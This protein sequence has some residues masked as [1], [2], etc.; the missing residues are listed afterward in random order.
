MTG[1]TEAITR[2]ADARDILQLKALWKTVFGDDDADIAHFFETYFSP[3]QTVVI[4]GDS[5]QNGEAK[6]VSVAYIIPV[7]EFVLN[8]PHNIGR[9]DRWY[10]DGGNPDGFSS[11]GVCHEGAPPEQTHSN[12]IRVQ[13]AMLYAIATLPECR[14]RGYGEAVTRAAYEQAIKIGFPAVVLKPADEGLFDFYEKRTEFRAFFDVSEVEFLANKMAASENTSSENTSSG[15]NPDAA[16]ATTNC[17]QYAL[18][19]VTP[20][21]YRRIRQGLLEGC[22]YIDM[23]ERSLAYQQ[24]LSEKAG[25]GLYTLLGSNEP[26]GCAGAVV[27]CAV[28]EP[29]GSTVKDS[30]SGDSDTIA[31]DG[32]AAYDG[33]GTVHIKELLLSPGCGLAD[34]VKA[35]AQLVKADR[36]IVRTLTDVDEKR[37]QRFGMMAPIMG[38]P[39]VPYVY[40]AKWYGLAFD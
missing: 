31:D 9:S 25:G 17:S 36:Y 12:G 21:E 2:L 14:G 39:V 10:H 5:I 7:G 19:P 15:D 6:P 40:S 26:N 34:A 35:A 23:D 13:C 24:Y 33:G 8:R 18:T 20:A 37:N 27:G 29:E 11:E 38:C 22:A 16:D 3:E 32:N 4:D 1:Q 28:I 30:N